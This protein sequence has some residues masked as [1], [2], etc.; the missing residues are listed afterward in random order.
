MY[1]ASFCFSD[2]RNIW[3]SKCFKRRIQGFCCFVNRILRCICIIHYFYRLIICCLK[4]FPFVRI[5]CILYES[6]SAFDGCLKI[7]FVYLRC[8]YRCKDFQV[9]QVCLLTISSFHNCTTNCMLCIFQIFFL[10]DFLLWFSIA[11]TI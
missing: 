9:I 7:R 11:R 6:S 10:K 2:F 3:I 8:L 1:D 4:C 5:I